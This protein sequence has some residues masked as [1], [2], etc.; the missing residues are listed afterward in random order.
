MNN[1]RKIIWIKA[2]RKLIQIEIL[3][4][5]ADPQLRALF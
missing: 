5:Q 2:D 3:D 1:K 4:I